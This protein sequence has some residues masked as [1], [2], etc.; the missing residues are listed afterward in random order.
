M[1][2]TL[3]L[4]LR[5]TRHTRTIRRPQDLGR[6]L[7][8]DH[9]QLDW[10]ALVVEEEVDQSQV[11][12]HRLGQARAHLISQPMDRLHLIHRM[13]PALPMPKCHRRLVLLLGMRCP[14]RHR[15]L[16]RTRQGG[17]CRITLVRLVLERC[18]F[19][20]A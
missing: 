11:R 17:R 13:D 1:A 6:P 12:R 16:C 4:R 7:L 14:L 3:H 18:F 2:T 15:R 8:A 10:E 20:E 9:T 5:P 19:L